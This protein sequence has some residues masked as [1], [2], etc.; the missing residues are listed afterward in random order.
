MDTDERNLARIRWRCHRGML[1]LDLF[2]QAFFDDCFQ[3]LTTS[4]QEQFELLLKETDPD[5][6]AWILG[7]EA[8]KPEFVELIEKIRQHNADHPT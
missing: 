5:I 1:E 8:V 4:E 6:W 2:L 7:Y 3:A